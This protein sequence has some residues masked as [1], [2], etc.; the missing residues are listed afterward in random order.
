MA[1]STSYQTRQRALILKHM[2]MAAG[3]HLTAAELAGALRAHGE[4]V[5][6]TTVYR[7]LDKLVAQGLVGKSMHGGGRAA[8][9]QYHPR[10][11]QCGTHFHL[12]C[13]DCGALTH[14]HCDLL[15]ELGAH[16]QSDHHFRLNP[17]A[18][19]FYGQCESCASEKKS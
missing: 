17:S 19:V 4:T 7:T 11:P 6:L 13:L 5:G 2:R 10:Q 18:T 15:G 14:L 8:C 1:T 3:A 9:Y 12:Q 16:M